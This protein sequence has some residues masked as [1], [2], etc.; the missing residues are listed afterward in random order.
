MAIQLEQTI[1]GSRLSF[2]C[3]MLTFLELK[4]VLNSLTLGGYDANRLVPHNVSFTLSSSKVPQTFINSITVTSP[5][6]TNA[7]ATTV[8]LLNT[9]DRVTAIIDSSTPFLW[10]P[11]TV[12]NRF[13]SALGLSYNASLN[14]YT[15]DSNA[16]QHDIL[17]AS[18]LSFTFSLSDFASATESVNITLPYAAFDL[19]LIYPA[20]PNTNYGDADST[21]YY[22]PLRQAANE[23]QYTIGRAFLQEAYLI[24]DYERNT[25]SVHQAVHVLDSIGNMSLIAITRPSS[26]TLTGNPDIPTADTKSGFPKGAIIGIALGALALATLSVALGLLLYRRNH[27]APAVSD[28]KVIDAPPPRPPRRS[29]IDRIVNR[30]PP[31]VPAFEAHGSQVYAVEVGADGPHAIHELPAPL[32][33][34][35]LESPS[36][37][38]MDGST[39][40]GS[41]TQDSLNISAYER[42]RR[43]MEQ[44]QNARII[45][46]HAGQNISPVEKTERDISPVAHYRPSDHQSLAPESPAHDSPMVSPMA[47][48][49][50]STLGINSGQPSPISPGFP[51]GL[52]QTPLSPPPTYRRINPDHVVYA[53]RLPDNVQLPNFVPRIVGPDGRIVQSDN[54]A[55]IPHEQDIGTHSSLGS[56]YT[57]HEAAGEL[58]LYGPGT[59]PALSPIHNDS[60]GSGHGSDVVSPLAST[61]SGSVAHTFGQYNSHDSEAVGTDM[62][63]AE[64]S[65]GG[66]SSN[67]S[68]RTLGA[69]EFVHVP[70]PAENRFS[71]EEERISGHDEEEN[72]I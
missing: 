56:Q 32:G 42:A 43:K 37:T 39:E 58:D 44:A 1:V 12:C 6:T 36:C 33:P 2:E 41:A 11:A 54:E 49:F 52:M 59:P 10:L 48:E 3:L 4:G 55:D 57:I 28:D 20:I 9:A 68:R 63:K 50:G 29:L 45:Q 25:F 60:L 17:A 13:A 66:S 14:L 24:A 69:E 5:G 22:F 23:A 62:L 64:V 47:A 7:T 35:E 61:S 34:V 71:W 26:S 70:Q 19:K 67:L 38:S 15:F 21:K 30:Q 18:R 53:G 72:S 8:S 46:A 27:Q 65:A 16:S 40:R 51:A 31:T